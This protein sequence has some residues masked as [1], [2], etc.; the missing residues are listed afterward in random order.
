MPSPKPAAARP[1]SRVGLFVPYA[2]LAAA[3]IG[4]SVYWCWAAAEVKAS[5]VAAG[6]PDRLVSVGASR[7]KVY[8]YPFRID[9]ELRDARFRA[10]GGL[11]L[12][13]PVLEAETYAYD[14]ARWIAV[15]PEGVS[16]V[17]PSGARV[18]WTAGALRGS[19]R[20]MPGGPEIVAEGVRSVFA[21]SGGARFP[22]ASAVRLVVRARPAGADR[23]EMLA[24]ASDATLSGA[25][26]G[27][28]RDVALHGFASGPRVLLAA[29]W[30]G[31][32]AAWSATGGRFSELSGGV[33]AGA[34][35]VEILGGALG[36]A[37]GGRLS[38]E[39]R[40]G[41][42]GDG[43]LPHAGPLAAVGADGAGAR[44]LDFQPDGVRLGD[45]RLG[46]SPRLD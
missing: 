3:A 35:G 29:P 24:Q 46:P 22:L 21:P 31:A 1:P 25:P 26:D 6:G 18:R 7:V 28:A 43:G 5:I 34:N 12:E 30:P 14:R 44:T 37:P 9:V 8:G 23:E 32:L 20:F 27:R 15:A 19:A 17:T 10:R 16:I 38:G 39:L 13:A 45:V 4:W 42:S 41:V 36:L 40:V 2:V 33:R 11:A